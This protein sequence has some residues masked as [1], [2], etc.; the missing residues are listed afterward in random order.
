MQK[1]KMKQE[2]GVSIIFSENQPTFRQT[3]IWPEEE[4]SLTV[5]ERISNTAGDNARAEMGQ[6]NEQV[7]VSPSDI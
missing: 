2:R 7:E 6:L 5:G 1:N 3:F 4:K